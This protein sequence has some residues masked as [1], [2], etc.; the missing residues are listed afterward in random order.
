MTIGEGIAFPDIVFNE[1][2]SETH[3]KRDG[4]RNLNGA[5]VCIVMEERWTGRRGGREGRGERC[6]YS[7][8]LFGR[9]VAGDCHVAGSAM[10]PMLMSK[11][12]GIVKA[13]ETEARRRL[14]K[15]KAYFL[16]P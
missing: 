6:R 8:P 4:G 2:D 16:P 7:S 13:K 5:Y 15:F 9:R 12:S 11:D 10:S 14:S 1:R 3:P